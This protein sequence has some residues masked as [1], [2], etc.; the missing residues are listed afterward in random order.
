MYPQDG[1]SSR[2]RRL[3]KS[4]WSWAIVLLVLI[5]LYM[6]FR[7]ITAIDSIQYALSPPELPEYQ[8]LE[9]HYVNPA[10]WPKEDSNWFHHASQGTATIP[11]PYQW[12]VALE[13]PKSNPWWI[14]FGE[15]GPFIGE[16][17]LRL[18]FIKQD[19]TELNPDALPIGIAKTESIYFPGIY[20][21]TTAEVY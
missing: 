6:A 4:K 18:G 20:H 21:K 8:Q 13:E 12:L 5:G 7:I 2:T 1:H 10:G 17:M 15:K 16:Y 9:T 11:V 3:V 14:F 19:A